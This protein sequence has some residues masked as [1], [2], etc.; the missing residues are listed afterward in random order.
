MGVIPRAVDDYWQYRANYPGQELKQQLGN[1]VHHIHDGSVPGEQLPV[2]FGLLL[3]LVGVM[4]GEATRDQVW[5]SLANYLPDAS[6]PA[7]RS[8][9][10][11]SELKTLMRI[12]N[13]Y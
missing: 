6:A 12:P 1:P 11:T 9:A 10:H 2:T 7:Y 5:G 13:A 4:G 3:N 8:E